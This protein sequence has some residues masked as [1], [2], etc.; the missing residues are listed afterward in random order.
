LRSIDPDGSPSHSAILNLPEVRIDYFAYNGDELVICATYKG[1]YDT[2]LAVYKYS[3]T[4]ERVYERVIYSPYNL[5]VLACY[6]LSNGT[7]VFFNAKYGSVEK[8]G[9]TVIYSVSQATDTQ[10]F[11]IGEDYLGCSVVP[12][13]EGFAFFGI[14]KEGTLFRINVDKTGENA[15]AREDLAE[16]VADITAFGDGTDYFAFVKSDVNRLYK[17]TNDGNLGESVPYFDGAD[18]VLDC[19]FSSS[20]ALFA[21]VKNGKTRMFHYPTGLC[22]VIADS[23]VSKL[24]IVYAGGY[25]FFTSM[26]VKNTSLKS[27]GGADVYYAKLQ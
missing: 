27:F 9:M 18:D 21:C 25:G 23:T 10:Y 8:T 19:A 16:N 13:G 20:G 2:V 5:S 11:N 26:D 15:S 22:G 14:T 1:N 3:Q 12:M 6:P 17:L 7:V 4:L 24:K